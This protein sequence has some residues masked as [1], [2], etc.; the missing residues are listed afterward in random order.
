MKKRVLALLLCLAMLLA[1]V[2]AVQ[3]AG[4][5]FTD[6]PQSAW[7]YS[8]VEFCYENA[9]FSGV[10]ETRFGPDVQMSRAMLV[11][12]LHRSSGKPS[13][14]GQA[15]FLDVRPGAWYYDAVQWAADC[16]VVYGENTAQG[17]AYAPDRSITR[18]QMVAILF[19]YANL[20]GYDTSARNT[21]AQFRDRSRVSSYALDAFRWAVAIGIVS[22]TNRTTLSPTGTATRSQVAPILMRFLNRYDDDPNNDPTPGEE[23]P[24]GTSDSV[25]VAGK[26][27]QIGMTRAQLIALAG[28]PSEQLSCLEGYTWYVYGTKTYEDFVMAGVYQDKIVALC[29]SG[30]GFYYQGYSMLDRNPDLPASSSCYFAALTDKNDGGRFHCIWVQA[31]SY[32]P[33]LRGDVTTLLANEARVDFHLVNAFRAYHGQ[34]ILSWNDKLATS[35]RLHS[36]DMAANH[37]FD[38]TGR[39]GSQPWDRVEAQGVSFYSCGENIAAGQ[40]NGIDVHNAWVNSA[41]HRANILDS[42]FT[43]MGTGIAYLNSSDYGVYYTENFIGA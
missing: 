35:A 9:L 10:S 4:V 11:A 33:T 23:I 25:Q 22:G 15:S 28:Q 6:T 21:L 41:G 31:K 1:A 32:N 2:P 5:P 38:H 34:R 43:Q 3:A 16:G 20:Q 42:G 37:Y 39:N 7:Y 36:A 26:S 27:Y 13:A 18:E 24:A 40:E 17:L 8:A 12:V 19:R 14:S 29:T 30:P